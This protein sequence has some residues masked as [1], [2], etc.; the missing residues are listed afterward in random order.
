MT[1]NSDARA[2]H[3]VV[4]ETIDTGVAQAARVTDFLLGGKDNYEADRAVGAQ[5]LRA[6]PALPAMFQARRAL[7]ARVVRYLVRD[8]GVR[9][10]LVIGPG[11]PSAGSVHAVAQAMAPASRVV[12]VEDDPVVLAHVRALMRGARQGR[13]AFAQGDLRR[14]DEILRHKSVTATL[15]RDRPIAVVLVGV[16]HHLRDA[17]RPHDA[18]RRLVEW[19][20]SGSY[21]AMSTASADFDPALM[22]SLI[23][24]AERAGLLVV[25]RSRAEFERFFIG[26]DLVEPG[27]VPALS[28]RPD[29]EPEDVDAVHGYVAVARTP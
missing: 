8:A 11:I 26:L 7:L 15:D 1:R 23:A 29:Q 18:V 19:L 17:D 24:I 16:I 13:T 20:P 27:V 12:Y 25:P 9:Q 4:Q 22:T 3:Y 21:L 28:W 14:P 2:G 5:L 6:A 10:F